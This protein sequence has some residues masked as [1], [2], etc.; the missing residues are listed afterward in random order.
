MELIG[1]DGSAATTKC[2]KDMQTGDPDTK[3]AI[4][5]RRPSTHAGTATTPTNIPNVPN[6]PRRTWTAPESPTDSSSSSWWLFFNYLP[7]PAD[8]PQRP[9]R[10]DELRKCL[11]TDPQRP[12]H[13]NAPNSH[14]AQSLRG[15]DAESPQG[16]NDE[17]HFENAVTNEAHRDEST[18]ASP[19]A[20][21]EPSGLMELI[22]LT[23]EVLQKWHTRH[24]RH[25]DKPGIAYALTGCG[26][27]PSPPLIANLPLIADTLNLYA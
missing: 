21:S 1:I 18:P 23:P 10:K 3:G 5:K 16:P 12:S 6:R 19:S 11:R 17:D 9:H 22:P 25:R 26:P 7:F 20:W 13:L 8:H 15:L 24:K 2:T 14:G 4:E 27:S